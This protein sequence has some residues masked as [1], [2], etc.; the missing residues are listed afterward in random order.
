MKL[1]FIL[2][3]CF[4]LISALRNRTEKPCDIGLKKVEKAKMDKYV[5]KGSNLG[6]DG[7]RRS[8]L[9]MDNFDLDPEQFHDD[10]DVN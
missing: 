5:E 8:H 3:L 9:K 10:E 2:T 6:R 4:A 7:L 1:F